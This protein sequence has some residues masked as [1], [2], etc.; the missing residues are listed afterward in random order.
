MGYLVIQAR[1]IHSLPDATKK[2]S[3]LEKTKAEGKAD[4]GICKNVS[5][6]LI[7]LRGFT[8]SSIRFVQVLFFFGRFLS[9][10]Q[11]FPFD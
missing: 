2:T 5:T 3:N 9:F 6:S 8:F 7:I 10:A 1:N 4:M 11:S